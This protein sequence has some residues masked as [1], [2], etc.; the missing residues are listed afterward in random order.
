MKLN[1]KVA[2]A[3]E[4]KQE[5][6]AGMIRVVRCVTPVGFASRVLVL[7]LSLA[8]VSGL[9][10]GCFKE[11]VESEGIKLVKEVAEAVEAKKR[12]MQVG[13]RVARCVTPVD[14]AFRV[15]VL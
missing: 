4:A 13:I 6:D 1:N 2:E 9:G 7:C 5:K 14:C 8:N 12:K 11:H 15:L 10:A 3:V